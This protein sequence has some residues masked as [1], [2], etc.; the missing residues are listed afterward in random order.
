MDLLASPALGADD[1]SESSVGWPPRARWAPA[2]V[3][4]GWLL[5]AYLHLRPAARVSSAAHPAAAYGPWSFGHLAYSDVIALYYAFHL[6][7][8]ALPYVHTAV[9]Y[10]VLTGMFMW[11]AAW[12]PGVQGYFLASS[13]GLL[14]SALGTVYF[15]HRINWRLAWSFAL[16]PLLL[17]YGL[18]NWDLLAIFFLVAGWAQF[19]ARRYAGAGILL[20]LGV[21]AKF[22]PLI[23]LF[24]CVV[25]LLR[26][27]RDRVHARRMVLWSGAVALIVNAPFAVMNV[28]NWDHFF[29]FNA[30]RGG[31]GGILYELHLASTLP[32]S[33]V[34]LLSGALVVLAVVLLV[35]RVLR[36]GSPMAA[37][38]ITFAVLLLVNK[39]SSPQYILWLFVLG[40]IAEWPVWSLVLMSVA[41][42]VNY[43]DAMMTLYLSRTHSPAF[44]WFFHTLYPW[45]RAL[46]N[47]TV[48]VGLGQALVTGRRSARNGDADPDASP[49]PQPDEILAP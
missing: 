44:S 41:G 18:L 5:W 27:P 29:V 38:A 48:A 30:R 4:T 26:D 11:L 9:E 23:V 2:V 17:V 24:Y 25:A 22:F 39:V 19:R 7:N 13:L 42:L 10:P 45:N 15:L 12:V 16:S 36:G 43:A 34:D 33:V 40:V 49:I 46:K 37:A 47:V 21:W 28:G 8:H 6:G 31:G 14:A 1:G 20:S 35:P 32:I 3:V